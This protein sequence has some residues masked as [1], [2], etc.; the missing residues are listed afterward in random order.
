MREWIGPQSEGDSA[1]VRRHRF[2]QSWYRA[3]VLGLPAGTGPTEGDSSRYGNMLT[4]EDANA[5]SNFLTREIHR[6]AEE[7][8]ASGG[9][10]EPFRC[11]RN[12]LSSQPMCFNLFGPLTSRPELAAAFVRNVT[13][14]DVELDDDGVR[15]EDS[16][17]HLDDRTGLDVSIRYRTADGR[18]GVLGIETKLSE[19][20]S[21]KVYGLDSKPAYRRYSEAA[22]SP[23]DVDQLEAL[24]RSRWNQLWR[25][26]LLCEAI[27]SHED[28]DF[29]EQVVVFPADAGR[30][31]SLVEEY[32]GLLAVPDAVQA[33]TL[34]EVVES[35]GGLASDDDQV[36][37]RGFRTR[38]IDLD[39]S[40][41]LL[42]AWMSAKP[43]FRSS[44]TD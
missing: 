7:R 31:E 28:R 3:L 42:D 44:G 35:L 4:A 26:Q 14:R 1:I 18:R 29:A 24:T 41:S 9:T 2:H 33:R 5:G 40:A 8:M 10:V 32:A 23:F 34:S 13:G 36:W 25:N 20:F 19:R 6:V 22:G 15:I 12:M 11:R 39:L 38:Y 27:R 21:P 17:G 16:P 30:T 37:L 43:P